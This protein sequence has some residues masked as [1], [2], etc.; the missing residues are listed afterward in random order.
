ME[1]IFR[2]C[3]PLLLLP[4]L[5]VS[6]V[7]CDNAESDADIFEEIRTAPVI[8][9]ESAQDTD[10]GPIFCDN[11]G[12]TTSLADMALQPSDEEFDGEWLYRFTYD[13]AEKVKNGHEIVVALGE[14]MM[15]IDGVTYVA[16][17]GVDFSSILEWAEGAYNY[18]S[19]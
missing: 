3:L 10:N 1:K 19:K 16:G 8:K 13:P 7:A 14:A 17:E 9:L 4:I 6:L 11:A 18:Y 12:T 2:I 5:L 15:E